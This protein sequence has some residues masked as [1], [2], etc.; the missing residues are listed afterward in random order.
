MENPY[1]TGNVALASFLLARGHPLKEISTDER[2]SKTFAFDAVAVDDARGFFLNAPAPA[3]SLLGH[4]R[5][6]SGALR[7]RI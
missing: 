6:L 7:E 1:R 5:D 4:L 3:R 2:G